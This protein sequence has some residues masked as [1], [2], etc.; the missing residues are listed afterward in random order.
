MSSLPTELGAPSHELTRSPAASRIGELAAESELFLAHFE[1]RVQ[2]DLPEDWIP[3]D[4]QDLAGSSVWQGGVLP[5]PKY[6][7]FR[8]DL[9][10]GSF[11]PGHRAKWTAHE[12]CHGL[13]GFGWRPGAS[14]LFLALAA[15]LAEALPVALWYFLDEA[16]LQRCHAHRGDGPLHGR[17]CSACEEAARGGSLVSDGDAER[18]RAEGVRFVER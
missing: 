17:Y 10:V 4:R 12:L 1:H 3:Q 8:H 2:L 16:G 13:V 11:H 6:Q 7:C 14:R 15:R 5:E 18:W 9:L